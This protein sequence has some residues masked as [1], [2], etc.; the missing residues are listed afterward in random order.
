MDQ[1]AAEASPSADGPEPA[2]DEGDTPVAEMAFPVSGEPMNGAGPEAHEN[3]AVQ[4]GDAVP[5][6]PPPDASALAAPAARW[7]RAS[8]RVSFD[9]PAIEQTAAQ[10]GSNQAMAKLLLAARAEGAHSR[11][12][13]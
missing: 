5:T 7:D 4:A 1:V 10:H 2:G 12:P 8:D 9:W 13:L 6:S 3:A 11:W